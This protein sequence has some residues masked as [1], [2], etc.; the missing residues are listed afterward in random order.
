MS[1]SRKIMCFD[2]EVYGF[3]VC[4]CFFDVTLFALNAD[5]KTVNE[6]WDLYGKHVDLKE[7]LFWNYYEHLYI[8]CCRKHVDWITST[9]YKNVFGRAS[10]ACIE[11]LKPFQLCC[12]NACKDMPDFCVNCAEILCSALEQ[13]L[14]YVKV[15]ENRR[16]CSQCKTR[17]K[18]LGV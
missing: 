2:R 14:Y 12:L 6:F 18:G 13:S 16:W 15:S 3:R 17:E 4:S 10:T 11:F 5:L 1:S 8:V 9:N 7:N